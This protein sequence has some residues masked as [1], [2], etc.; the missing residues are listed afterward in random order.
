[1]TEH[2]FYHLEHKALEAVL[3]GLLETC[4]QRDWRSVICADEPA[5]LA[6]LSPLLWSARD[7]SFLAHAVEGDSS[8]EAF[9]ADQPIWLSCSQENPNG[10]YVL[11]RI[12]TAEAAI[13]EAFQRFV[14][15]FDGRDNEAV[16][17][18]R[19]QWTRLKDA[20]LSPTYWQQTIEGKWEKR[21]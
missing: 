12:G 5:A 9:K 3:P 15:L 13:S 21:G 6:A 10:A 14:Y 16:A 4:L 17:S 7:N 18:A 11:F 2:L 19:A 8:M 1:M 20:G